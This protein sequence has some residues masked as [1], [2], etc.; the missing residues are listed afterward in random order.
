MRELLAVGASLMQPLRVIIAF[1]TYVNFFKAT[2]WPAL[3][4]S[5]AIST[6]PSLA[7]WM[8]AVFP[9]E[10]ALLMSIPFSSS[11]NCTTF[12]F[13]ILDAQWRAVFPELST[14][15]ISMSSSFRSTFV[16]SKWPCFDAY[17]KGVSPIKSF[18]LISTLLQLFRIM[19]SL[20]KLPLL[21]ASSSSSIGFAMNGQSSA[22]LWCN[23]ESDFLYQWPE[24]VWLTSGRWIFWCGWT[25]TMFT[26]I[27]TIGTG[28]A[29]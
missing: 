27:I 20:L 26:T 17:I 9:F 2:Y 11:S 10:S 21:D 24:N 4:R 3:W 19:S 5:C 14:L 22:V 13:A 7:A 18:V 28:Q 8:R 6:F 23:T 1:Q 25:C 15:L 16:I 12:A 29:S